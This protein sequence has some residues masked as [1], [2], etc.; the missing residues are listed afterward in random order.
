MWHSEPFACTLGLH[1]GIHLVNKSRRQ[2]WHRKQHWQNIGN[3]KSMEAW[4]VTCKNCSQ[5]FTDN[6]MENKTVLLTCCGINLT[7]IN[8]TQLHVY[9]KNLITVHFHFP[10]SHPLYYGCHVLLVHSGSLDYLGYNYTCVRPPNS[11]P[12]VSD[13]PFFPYV[14]WEISKA[15]CSS[16]WFLLC[17][18][19]RLS[20]SP[21][22][23]S[24]F[25]HPR[26]VCDTHIQCYFLRQECHFVYQMSS[27]MSLFF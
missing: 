4:N 26:Y 17:C 16:S 7:F 23:P 11:L 14:F 5:M 6:S 1:V 13:V 3:S 18:Y 12:K 22:T 2:S 20:P 8:I 9:S 25:L 15:M 21:S 24:P 19:T 27:Y 10:P